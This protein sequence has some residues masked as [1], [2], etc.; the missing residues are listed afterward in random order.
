[1]KKNIRKRRKEKRRKRRE[2]RRREE[3]RRE[4]YKIEEKRKKKKIDCVKERAYILQTFYQKNMFKNTLNFK[5]N[6][7]V[8][9]YDIFKKK[10]LS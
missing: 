10:Q 2:E 3:N 1:M 5:I 4:Q 9:L 6:L 7:I 8:K